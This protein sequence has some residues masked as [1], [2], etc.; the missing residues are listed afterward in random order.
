MTLNMLVELHGTDMLGLHYLL[1][2]HYAINAM[3]MCILCA[4][5]DDVNA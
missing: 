2:L 1:H 4:F 5:Y 3:S